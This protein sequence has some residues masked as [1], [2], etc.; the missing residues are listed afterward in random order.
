MSLLNPS[1]VFEVLSPSTL[2]SVFRVE[3]A[4]QGSRACSRRPC[5]APAAAPRLT[6][7]RT[8]RR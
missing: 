3:R 7:G 6:E 8:R 2:G 1:L 4:A 5:C